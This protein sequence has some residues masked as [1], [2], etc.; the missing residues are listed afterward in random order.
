M[1]G[2]TKKRRCL[3]PLLREFAPTRLTEDLLT[4]VYER[5]LGA[6][7]HRG[8]APAESPPTDLE[9]NCVSEEQIVTTGGQS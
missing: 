1:Q 3:P 2:K 8:P 5:L 4:S 9:T 7:H 6:G